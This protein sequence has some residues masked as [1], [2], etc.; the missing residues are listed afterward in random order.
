MNYTQEVILQS[1][2]HYAPLRIEEEG[3]TTINHHKRV[4]K[5]AMPTFNDINYLMN[6]INMRKYFPL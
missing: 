4:A 5:V 2:S 6:V 3:Q 1:T